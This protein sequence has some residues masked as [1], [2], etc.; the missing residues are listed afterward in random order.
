MLCGSQRSLDGKVK[1]ERWAVLHPLMKQVF[2]DARV[3][4]HLQVLSRLGEDVLGIG[5]KLVLL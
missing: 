4:E 5:V 3:Y 2:G 1:L